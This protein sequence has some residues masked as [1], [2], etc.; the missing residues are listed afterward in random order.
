MFKL[1][2]LPEKVSV[3]PQNKLLAQE[4]GKSKWQRKYCKVNILKNKDL[5]L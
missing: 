3:N 1:G 5:S 4:R 2:I